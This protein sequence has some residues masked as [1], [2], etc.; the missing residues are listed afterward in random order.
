LFT[1]SGTLFALGTFPGAGQKIATSSPQVVG[2]IRS[3]YLDVA[4]Q[5]VGS[6]FTVDIG[7]I[8]TISLGQM[9]ANLS[10]QVTSRQLRTALNNMNMLGNVNSAVMSAGYTS[11]AVIDWMSCASVSPN[12]ALMSL[13]VA[14][15]GA[16]DG[17]AALL[18]AASALPP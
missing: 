5:N 16:T 15:I 8:S 12:S 9:L 2:N 17:G 4:Y 18:A 10:G 7:N 14:A 1:S 13:I 3:L 11:Q 6:T